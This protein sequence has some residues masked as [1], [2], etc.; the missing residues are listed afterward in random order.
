MFVVR[1]DLTKIHSDVVLIPTD[2]D[3][4]VTR[5]WWGMFPAEHLERSVAGWK[6]Y[7]GPLGDGLAGGAARVADGRSW[8]FIAGQYRATPERLVRST[9]AALTAVASALRDEKR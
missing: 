1:G 5:H 3:L 9:E 8:L 2:D 4:N 7:V 6:R